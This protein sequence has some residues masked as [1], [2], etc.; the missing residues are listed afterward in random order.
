[1]PPLNV[2]LAEA[3]AA[4]LKAEYRRVLRK[5]TPAAIKY[6][7]AHFR[8]NLRVSINCEIQALAGFLDANEYKNHWQRVEEGLTEPGENDTIRLAVEK[9]VLG[10]GDAGSNIIYGSANTGNSGAR[11]YGN[12]CLVLRT[13]SVKDRVSFL[14]EN[15]MNYFYQAMTGT[16]QI[17]KVPAGTRAT[18]ENVHQLAAVKVGAAQVTRHLNSY[19]IPSVNAAVC[20][21]FDCLEAQV[22]GVITPKD[23]EEVRIHQVEY[24]RSRVQA[25]RPRLNEADAIT[26]QFSRTAFGLLDSKNIRID[27]SQ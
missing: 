27:V 16:R 6:F 3:D 15:S 24:I 4:P 1:M 22:F 10:F 2:E 23:I 21:F 17:A 7:E 9:G 12:V 19:D 18:W 20:G 5:V 8:S 13:D 26:L 25:E 11:F 14:K